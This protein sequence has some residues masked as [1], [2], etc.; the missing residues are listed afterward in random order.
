[1]WVQQNIA[2]FGGDPNNVTIFGQSAGGSLVHYQILSPFSEGTDLISAFG[3]VLGYDAVQSVPN[4][5]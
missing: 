1:M 2:V 3:Q 5:S 4:Q